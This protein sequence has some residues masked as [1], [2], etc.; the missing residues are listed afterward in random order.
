MEILH[1]MERVSLHSENIA[2]D[3]MEIQICH[4]M[5]KDQL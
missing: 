4:K 1:G 5:G 3:H 2:K